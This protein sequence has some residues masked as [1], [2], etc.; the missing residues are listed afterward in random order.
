M[1][2]DQIEVFDADVAVTVQ[3]ASQYALSHYLDSVKPLTVSEVHQVVIWAPAYRTSSR[4]I[5]D[6]KVESTV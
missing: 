4:N 3:V 6:E 1:A 5:V 2:G